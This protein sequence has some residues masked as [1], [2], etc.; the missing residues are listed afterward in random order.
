MASG[1]LGSSNPS[2]T[3]LTTVYTVPSNKTAVF[4]VSVANV[5]G[6]PLTFR[7]A[8]ATTT[9][10]ATSEYV[11]Y[12]TTVPGYGVFERG[13]LVASQTKN[14]VVYVSNANAAVNV[15]GYED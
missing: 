3:T 9:T 4:N 1:T 10:P 13:G 12:E 15:Y 7:L 14:V 8:I 6:L 11:E 2:A 5:S